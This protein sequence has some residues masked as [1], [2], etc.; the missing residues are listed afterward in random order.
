MNMAKRLKA[1]A[2][3]VIQ[4]A[5]D[6]LRENMM[7]PVVSLVLMALITCAVVVTSLVTKMDADAGQFMQRTLSTYMDREMYELGDQLSHIT[8]ADGSD[9]SGIKAFQRE[10]VHLSAPGALY[11]YI[12]D[13]QG[14]VFWSQAPKGQTAPALAA[15]SPVGLQAL[16]RQPVQEQGR[17]IGNS[18]VALALFD[19]RPAMFAAAPLPPQG[20]DSV[21]HPA[22][23]AVL[24]QKIDDPAL[25]YWNTTFHLL[26]L[27]WEKGE[28]RPGYRS[29]DLTDDAGNKIGHIV[30]PSYR[31]GM[32]A[33]SGIL[34]FISICGIVFA[35]LS[36]WLILLIR[37]S[38]LAMELSR[39]MAIKLSAEATD[40]ARRAE[41]ARQQAE[42][43]LADAEGARR[44]ADEMARREVTEQALHRQQLRENSHH[45][46]AALQESMSSLVKQLIET[47]NDLE[48]SAELTIGTLHE[49]Q[50]QADVVRVRSQDAAEAIAAVTGGIEELTG[51]IAEIRK[52]A[53]ESRQFAQV[54][55]DHSAAARDAN[56]HLLQQ[57]SSI[58]DA[59]SIIASIAK[60]TN[61]LALNAAI[62]AARA[63]S[64]GY[65]FA[66]VANEVKALASETART[67]GDIHDRVD[68]IETAARSTVNLVGSLDEMLGSLVQAM[69]SSSAT[70]QQQQAVAENIRRSSR[71]VAENAQVAAQAV[72]AIS[73][74]LDSIAQTA[75]STR[76]I[77]AAVRNRAEHLNTEFAR[78]VQQLEAA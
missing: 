24:V 15:A 78:L 69:A 42:A 21:K 54:A 61:L 30:W 12:I 25:H 20:A 10:V 38:C 11:G 35:A 18:R 56:D 46:A 65:G 47:A 43:A 16:L 44:R 1:M 3:K 52:A 49:Q 53:E 31:V 26:G 2:G 76:H 74:S 57:V 29:I 71:G 77:G 8:R 28:P 13:K 19:S 7:L 22:R 6:G 51:S 14:R 70:V 48:L 36:F 23:F 60:Q 72:E 75:S 58:N 27:K 45:M 39:E 4:R 17:Q 55:S 40:N 50:K 59:A 34:P 64:S 73:T 63:G 37:R 41:Q 9:A 67:T 5:S 66:V 62:E 33:F 68:G 32:K